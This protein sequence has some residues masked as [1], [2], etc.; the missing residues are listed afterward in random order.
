MIRAGDSR[1]ENHDLA[2]C[3]KEF[4]VTALMRLSA[5]R[6]IGIGF[7]HGA[8]HRGEGHEMMRALAFLTVI[9][10]EEKNYRNLLQW[11]S[12]RVECPVNRPT[13]G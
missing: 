2:V 7:T 9:G 5:T 4:Q 11:I 12:A 1:I 6:M 3:R 10:H 13:K 8:T